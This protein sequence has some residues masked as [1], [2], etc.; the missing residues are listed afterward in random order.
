MLSRPLPVLGAWALTGLLALAV[1]ASVYRIPIQ[2]SDS[3]E[4]M[5][6]VERSPSVAAAFGMGLRAST[7]MLRPMR[8]AQTKALLDLAHRLGDRYNVVFRGFHATTAAALILL[9]AAAARPRTWPDVAALAFALTV[10]TG[11]HTFAGMVREAYPINHFLLVSLYGLATMLLAQSRGGLLADIAGCAVFALAALTLESGLLVWVVAAAAYLSGLRG[12][13][14]GALVAMTVLGVAYVGLRVGYLGMSPSALGD[15]QTGF[16]LGVLS[17]ADEHARFGGAPLLLYAYTV[18]AS[19]MTVLFS[20]P[21][22]GVWTALQAWQAGRFTPVYVIELGTSVAAT[23]LL[24]W[25]LCGRTAPDGPRRWRSPVPLVALAVLV[26]NAVQ[27][28]AYAKNEIMSVSGVFYALLTYAAA[29][30]AVARL[31]RRAQGWAM[32]PVLVAV[33]VVSGAWGFR[34]LGLQYKLQR[35][36]YVARSEWV[37]D[38]PPYRTVRAPGDGFRLAPRLRQEALLRG[39]TNPFMLPLWTAAYWGEE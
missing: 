5:E 34:S 22:V 26:A 17:V 30:E 27:S 19:A 8:Q 4:I 2:V 35:G 3:L 37:E 28:Y 1:A 23:C 25:H 12:L 14:R 31:S 20:Q 33:V 11:L 36:A 7:T 15:R 9:F 32:V 10:L 6:T 18:I 16:G 39:R 38:M 13:S 21:S 24:A 29:R